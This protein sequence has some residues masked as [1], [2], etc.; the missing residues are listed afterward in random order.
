MLETLIIYMFSHW[1]R[2]VFANMTEISILLACC[3]VALLVCC[4][5]GL[6]VMPCWFVI[7]M[8]CQLLFGSLGLKQ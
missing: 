7:L 2:L 6:L 1:L 4:L 5:A 8:A 3:F